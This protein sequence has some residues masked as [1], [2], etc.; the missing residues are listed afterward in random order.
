MR[1]ALGAIAAAMLL[2]AGAYAAEMTKAE[3]KAAEDRIAADFGLDRPEL[4][5]LLVVQLIV[6]S[7]AV[8]AD[9]ERVAAFGDTTLGD[10]NLNR[11]VRI[12][13][14]NTLAIAR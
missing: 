9:A 5:R 14:E 2:S 10:L 3:H 6:A 12:A 13:A 1:K 4:L 11:L 7:E 8:H